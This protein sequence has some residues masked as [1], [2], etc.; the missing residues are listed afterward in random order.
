M[1]GNSTVPVPLLSVLEYLDQEEASTPNP[2]DPASPMEGPDTPAHPEEPVAAAAPQPKHQ[3]SAEPAEEPATPPCALHLF[4]N[5]KSPT[6]VP[7]TPL[8]PQSPDTPPVRLRRVPACCDPSPTSCAHCTRHPSLPLKLL[9][10]LDTLNCPSVFVC[11]CLY[12]PSFVNSPAWSL[13][14][15]GPLCAQHQ[16]ANMQCSQ[17]GEP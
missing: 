3:A 13:R 10:L 4:F 7:Q 15:Q 12:L 17:C 2:D 16:R 1:P 5:L 11:V 9:H 8:L 14:P 6:P